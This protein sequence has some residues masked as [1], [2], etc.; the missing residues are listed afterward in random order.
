MTKSEYLIFVS[1][2]LPRQI[3][4]SI[5]KVV[6]RVAYFFPKLSK[7]N[8]I[9]VQ[10]TLLTIS[11]ILNHNKNQN[12]IQ[13]SEFKHRQNQIGWWHAT[14]KKK[15]SKYSGNF[16]VISKFDCIIMRCT[17]FQFS[18]RRYFL[19]AIPHK[20]VLYRLIILRK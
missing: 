7:T 4:M 6:C 1:G 14:D 17:I 9:L 20:Y 5:E 16:F 19:L 12:N 10:K 2:R 11:S 18:M 15:S 3:L 8:F 13:Y